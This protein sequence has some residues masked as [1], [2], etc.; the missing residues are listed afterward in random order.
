MPIVVKARGNDTTGDVIRKFK[1]IVAATDIVQKV[2]DRTYY[3][4]PSEKRTLKLSEGRR[5]KKRLR[6]LK[7]MKNIPSEV[8][9][10]LT[11]SL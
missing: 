9:S 6:S 2:K 5:A 3:Q 11:K 1:K 4:S 10:R 8:I 7:K